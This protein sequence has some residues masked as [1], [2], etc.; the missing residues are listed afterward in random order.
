MCRKCFPKPHYGNFN[1]KDIS[2][3]VKSVSVDIST[4]IRITEIT[5]WDITMQ[6]YVKFCIKVAFCFVGYRH[7]Y[8]IDHL[9]V[10]RQLH[11][12]EMVVKFNYV[13][14]RGHGQPNFNRRVNPNIFFYIL[15][16]S[17]WKILVFKSVNI[18]FGY[19][20]SMLSGRICTGEICLE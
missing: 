6:F 8:Y 3:S 5:Q 16:K 14:S 2:C 12:F 10:S 7:N 1:L 20:Y 15:N 9:S 11:I 17:T 13:V 19:A 4:P 18:F